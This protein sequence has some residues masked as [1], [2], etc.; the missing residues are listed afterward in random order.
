MRI[1][2]KSFVGLAIDGAA[3]GMIHI[4]FWPG[5]KDR[6]TITIH[7][8]SK[9]FFVATSTA[10]HRAPPIAASSPEVP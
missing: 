8:P 7:T 2:R 10:N 5:N 9:T 6:T 1:T 3:S 4:P